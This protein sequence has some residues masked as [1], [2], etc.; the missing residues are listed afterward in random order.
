MT[1][2]NNEELQH[3]LH[4]LG[5][6]F[7]DYKANSDEKFKSINNIVETK[8]ISQESQLKTPQTWNNDTKKQHSDLANYLCSGNTDSLEYKNSE[9]HSQENGGYVCIPDANKMIIA[10]NNYHSPIR[11]LSNIIHVNN[12]SAYELLLMEPANVI[13][14]N[15]STEFKQENSRS[16]T[17]DSKKIQLHAL[18]SCLNISHEWV[19][20]TKPANFQDFIVSKIANDISQKE[21]ELFIEGNDN[22]DSIIPT[23]ATYK[24]K[25]K[26][27]YDNIV[28][29]VSKLPDE[30]HNE[31]VFLMTR[32]VY[33]ELLKMTDKSDRPLIRVDSQSINNYFLNYP[34]HFIPELAG[35]TCELIFCNLNKGYTVVEHKNLYNLHDQYSKKPLIQNYLRKYIGAKVI[36]PDAFVGLEI[37]TK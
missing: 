31:A 2:I 28:S 10:D 14:S 16:L 15:A 5:K 17:M 37:E 29:M 27:N 12:S 3:A 36:R 20:Q 32:S 33:A 13:E 18:E 23:D 22:I 26:L 11:N 19:W 8:A 34:I 7:Q 9:T 1:Q 6:S 25:S 4:A 35:K 30:F 24:I 21:R